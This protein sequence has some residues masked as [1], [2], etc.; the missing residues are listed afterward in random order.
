MPFAESLAKRAGVSPEKARQMLEDFRPRVDLAA[1]ADDGDAL[2]SLAVEF[3][4][5]LERERWARRGVPR[6]IEEVAAAVRRALERKMKAAGRD[7]FGLGELLMAAAVA[8][9]GL[10][11]KWPVHPWRGIVARRSGEG[12]AAAVLVWGVGT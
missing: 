1:R 2:V 11:R 4:A 6:P 5:V 8:D 7:A 10:S 12:P 3:G 9:A